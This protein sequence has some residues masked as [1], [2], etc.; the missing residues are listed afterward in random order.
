MFEAAMKALVKRRTLPGK[1]AE[2]LHRTVL[3]RLEGGPIPLRTALEGTT[4][5]EDSERRE[6]ARCHDLLYYVRT[7][8]ADSGA[9]TRRRGA[10]VPLVAGQ[11]DDSG[12][13][14]VGQVG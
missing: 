14:A 8:R 9:R 7:R 2:G 6:E 13:A 11:V 4:F 5:P 10:E 12:T 1:A 3:V